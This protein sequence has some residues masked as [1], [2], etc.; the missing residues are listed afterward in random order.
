MGRM[1]SCGGYLLDL[2]PCNTGHVAGCCDCC[3]SLRLPILLRRSLGEWMALLS[4]IPLKLLALWLPVWLLGIPLIPVVVM[5]LFLLLLLGNTV[6]IG[7]TCGMA[8]Y[9]AT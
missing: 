3:C 8:A 6:Y 1:T 2:P 4:K 9:L 5:C 7:P